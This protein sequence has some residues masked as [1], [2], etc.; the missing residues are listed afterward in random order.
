MLTSIAKI[1]EWDRIE[2]AFREVF[3]RRWYTNSGPLV[4]KVEKELER[5]LNAKHVICMT[6]YTIAKEIVRE[7]GVED[8]SLRVISLY[9]SVSMIPGAC[10]S[11][12]RDRTGTLLRNMRSSYGIDRQMDVPLTGNGRMSEAQALMI[13]LALEKSP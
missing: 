6:N 1:I 13:L 2:T 8:P 11:T 5:Y 4:R 7:A 12:D 3:N 10:V 9:P